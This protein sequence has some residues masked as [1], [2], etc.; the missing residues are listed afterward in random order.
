MRPSSRYWSVRLV[1]GA[2]ASDPSAVAQKDTH[3]TEDDTRRFVKIF[4]ALIALN[5]RNAT[6]AVFV[7]AIQLMRLDRFVYTEKTL[8]R[9][10]A[11]Y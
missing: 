11:S 9:L 8:R 7:E 5:D 4:E 3:M 1:P 10:S 6:E 2:P